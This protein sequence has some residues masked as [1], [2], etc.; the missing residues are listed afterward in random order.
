MVQLFG[1]AL[2]RLRDDA[3]RSPHPSGAVRWVGRAAAHL[4]HAILHEPLWLET[5]RLR[6]PVPGLLES[7]SGLRIAHLSDFHFSRKIPSSYMERAI[8]L[9]N[10]LEPDVVVLTGDF[11]QAGYRHVRRMSR[12]VGQLR[13]PLGVHAVLGNHDYSMRWRGLQRHRYLA[14]AV[15]GALQSQGVHVLRNQCHHLVRG[16]GGLVL[17]GLDDLWAGRCDVQEAMGQ[18]PTDAV[19]VVLVHNPLALERMA[20]HACDL[21]LSGHT[22]GGQVHLPWFGRPF[23]SR[24]LRRY[25]AG[26]HRAGSTWLYVSKG[27]GFHHRIRYNVRPEIALVE[28]VRGP[29]PVATPTCEHRPLRWDDRDDG[30]LA[31]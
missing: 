4:H 30:R 19:R 3:L 12:L 11:I 31:S 27:I 15:R 22:H 24:R 6:I 28:L 13:A 7:L 23:L 8:R 2:R 26:L 14:D 17:V 10:R 1:Q 25:A 29:T 21:V 20:G 18:A 9:T 5:N 16:S